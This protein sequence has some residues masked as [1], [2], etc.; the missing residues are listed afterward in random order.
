MITANT[1]VIRSKTL[2]CGF[3]FESNSPSQLLVVFVFFFLF[4]FSSYFCFQP[5]LSESQ[6]KNFRKRDLCR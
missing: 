5:C 4:S 1:R 6:L 3:F 2:G